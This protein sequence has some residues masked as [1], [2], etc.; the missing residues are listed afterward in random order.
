MSNEDEEK[1]KKK[2]EELDWLR[3]V[4]DHFTK[5]GSF[6]E[7]ADFVRKCAINNKYGYCIEVIDG[8]ET[9]VHESE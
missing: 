8:I 3:V 7:D 9:V 6:N 2:N 4:E 1:R 5:D